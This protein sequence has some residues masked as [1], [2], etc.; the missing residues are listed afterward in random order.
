M[1]SGRAGAKEEARQ[2]VAAERVRPEDVGGRRRGQQRRA[3]LQGV[4]GSEDRRA[5][6]G[7]GEHQDHQPRHGDP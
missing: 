3:H 4:V 5:Q 1:R 6:G 2:R 7:E